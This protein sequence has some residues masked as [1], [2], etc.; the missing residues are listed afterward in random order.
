MKIG[1]QNIYVDVLREQPQNGN[2]QTISHA[3]NGQSGKNQQDFLRDG[4]KK[5]VPGDDTNNED[6]KG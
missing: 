6:G 3:H 1:V 2:P 4:R 5:Q